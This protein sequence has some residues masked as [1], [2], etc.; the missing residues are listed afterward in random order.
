MVTMMLSFLAVI[1]FM[2]SLMAPIAYALLMEEYGYWEK[3]PVKTGFFAL[4]ILSGLMGVSLFL[5]SV[6]DAREFPWNNAVVESS[7]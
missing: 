6:V 4:L 5:G 3:N 2:T 1:M 7:K